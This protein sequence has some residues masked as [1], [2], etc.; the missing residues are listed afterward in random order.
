MIEINLLPIRDIKRRAKAK[1]ELALGGLIVAAF[2]ALLA[3]FG[4]VLVSTV[5]NLQAE[6]AAVQNEKRQYDTQ[7]KEIKE[8]EQRKENLLRM[9]SVIEQLEKASP[10]AVHVLDEVASRTPPDRIWLTDVSKSGSQMQIG[11]MSLDN[12]TVA[13]YMLDLED[14]PY[15]SGLSLVKSDT[16]SYADRELKAFNLR[17]SIA[18]PASENATEQK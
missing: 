18:V 10:L 16:R 11:G 9:I 1:K 7:L 13:K 12:Q 14:S 17:S 2:L 15:M 6:L 3:L 4:I 8:L 5:K